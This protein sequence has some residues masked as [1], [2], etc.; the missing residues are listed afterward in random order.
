MEV[1]TV[2]MRMVIP[3]SEQEKKAVRSIERRPEKEP[4]DHTLRSQA[5]AENSHGLTRVMLAVE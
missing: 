4:R 1:S 2:M 3:S 5:S